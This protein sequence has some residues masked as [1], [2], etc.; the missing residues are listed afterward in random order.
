MVKCRPPH[1][2][3]PLPEESAACAPFLLRQ[4]ALLRPKALLGMGKIASQFLLKTNEG[5]TRIR[6]RVVRYNDCPACSDLPL[7]PTFHPSYL[8]RN[9]GEKR[10]AWED[11][12][13]LCVLLAKLDAAYAEKPVVQAILRKR[14]VAS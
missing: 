2:R 9:E 10:F 12:Q 1:N 6:G 11:L 8:L 14:G 4:M 3:D 7:M 13:N 5:I